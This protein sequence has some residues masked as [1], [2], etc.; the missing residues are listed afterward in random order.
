MDVI[1]GETIAVIRCDSPDEASPIA[2]ALLEGGIDI[3]EVTMTVRS[4]R[5]VAAHGGRVGDR[6][7]IGAGTVLDK[8]STE[9]AIDAG[10]SFI[11]SPC[12]IP[13]V[14]KPHLSEGALHPGL[15]LAHGGAHRCALGA[16]VV[17]LSRLCSRTAIRT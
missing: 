8:R 3:I 2:H 1:S 12:C 7:L 13:E 4:H 17:K 11:V 16:L 15:L 9:Q 6:A 10:S 5:R 14:I